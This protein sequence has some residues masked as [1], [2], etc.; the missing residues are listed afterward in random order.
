MDCVMTHSIA[1]GKLVCEKVV[2]VLN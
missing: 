2:P 1:A